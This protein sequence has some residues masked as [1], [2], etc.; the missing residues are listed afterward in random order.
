MNDPQNY[1]MPKWSFKLQTYIKD[2]REHSPKKPSQ[3]KNEPK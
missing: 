3:P 2:L 1:M